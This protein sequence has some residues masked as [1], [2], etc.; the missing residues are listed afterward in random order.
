MMMV[1]MATALF[2]SFRSSEEEKQGTSSD[3]LE[4]IESTKGNIT[5]RQLTE[6]DLLLELNQNTAD[7]YKSLS[8]E[9]QQLA[10]KLA[11]RSC[12][13]NNDC[14]GT[15]ACRTTNNL[16]AGQG[17]CKGLTKCAFSDKNLAVKVAAKKM[18]EKRK[19]L[20]HNSLPHK[21]SV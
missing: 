20:Q 1:G 3:F 21:P 10:L 8:P 16:C 6:D 18:A 4:L 11:S 15:N 14:A 9:G 13:G 5:E 17:K 2:F 12:N 7:L 19:E